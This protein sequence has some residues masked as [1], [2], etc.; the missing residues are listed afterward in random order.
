MRI[1]F[2]FFV[3]L[4]FT[5]LCYS[6]TSGDKSGE[7][8]KEELEIEDSDLLMK[9]SS[10]VSDHESFSKATGLF[11]TL[12][13]QDDI[14]DF[15]LLPFGEEAEED[16][17][18]F[19]P[20]V[21]LSYNLVSGR[22]IAEE[23]TN[24]YHYTTSYKKQ[25]E[26]VMFSMYKFESSLKMLEFFMAIDSI[27]SENSDLRIKE[28]KILDYEGWEVLD[29]DGQLIEVC[30]VLPDTRLIQGSAGEV[31]KGDLIELLNELE[32]SKL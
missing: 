6:C 26:S 25:E 32:L 21:L 12:F 8:K 20:G 30:L 9:S 17:S 19:F 23:L 22:Q 28:I 10:D 27:Y 31:F 2:F 7:V 14:S 5:F 24:L 4:F 13:N 16:L 29:K 11:K 18:D 1:T 15:G 3:I